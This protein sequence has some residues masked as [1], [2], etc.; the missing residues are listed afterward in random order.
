MK[1][2]EVFADIWCPFAHVGI[3]RPSIWRLGLPT[4]ARAAMATCS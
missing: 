3:L 1:T 4:R 2:I